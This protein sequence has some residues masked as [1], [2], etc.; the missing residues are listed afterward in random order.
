MNFRSTKF[1]AKFSAMSRCKPR[2]SRWQLS[3]ESAPARVVANTNKQRGGTPAIGNRRRGCAS[4]RGL[5]VTRSRL[6]GWREYPQTGWGIQLCRSA[7]ARCHGVESRSHGMSPQRVGYRPSAHGRTN[8]C[9]CRPAKY[10]TG[11]PY[12]PSRRNPLE[13]HWWIIYVSWLWLSWE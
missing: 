10:L 8:Y 7:N 13:G 12:F 5:G 4:H 2:L 6:Q 1:S 9:R 3:A 11:T